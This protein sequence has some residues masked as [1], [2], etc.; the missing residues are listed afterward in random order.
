ML[1]VRDAL[2][3]PQESLGGGDADIA[4]AGPSNWDLLHQGSRNP[5]FQTLN[6]GIR[7]LK[8][9]YFG[10]RRLILRHATRENHCLNQQPLHV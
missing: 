4:R 10:G 9:N 7:A 3:L 8:S 6:P 5:E 1:G 2:E